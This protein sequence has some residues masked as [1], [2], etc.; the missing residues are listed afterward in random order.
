MGVL[1]FGS[2]EVV[3]AF[4]LGGWAG[5]EIG[6]R[7]EARAALEEVAARQEVNLLVV[8]EAVAEMARGEIDRLKLEGGRLLVVE[9]PGFAGPLEE[10]RTPLELVRRALGIHL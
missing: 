6:S 1:V 3:T 2:K 4:A 7:A 9:V 10:R 5:R 8:E